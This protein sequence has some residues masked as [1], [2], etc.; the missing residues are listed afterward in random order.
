MCN[1][2]IP[3]LTPL[4]KLAG[5]TN[6]DSPRGT[7]TAVGGGIAIKT[8]NTGDSKSLFAS[9]SAGPLVVMG[10]ATPMDGGSYNVR[11]TTPGPPH[12][13][14]SRTSTLEMDLGRHTALLLYLMLA[15]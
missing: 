11:M 5:E 14:A 9:A 4:A 3:H 13:Q 15:I 1:C 7:S 10:P 12:S 2:Q 8:P 6:G